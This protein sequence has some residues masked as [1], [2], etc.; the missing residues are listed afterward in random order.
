MQ[1]IFNSNQYTLNNTIKISTDKSITHR[2]IMLGSIAKGVTTVSDYLNSEDCLATLNIMRQLGVNIEQ[3]NNKLKINGVGLNGLKEPNDVLN[4]KNS[5]TTM[6][7]VSGILAAQNFMSVITGDKSLNSRP[8]KRIITP[9]TQMGARMYGKEGNN[10]A[11]LCILPVTGLSSIQYSPIVASAQVKSCVLLA[12][13]YA[14]GETIIHEKAVTRNHTENMLKAMAVD[15]TVNDKTIKLNGNQQLKAID[16]QVPGDFSTAAYFITL[17][18]CSKNSRL[19]I[20]DVGINET[21][22]G[23][24][25]VLIKMGANIKVSN[26]HLCNNEKIADLVVTSSQLQATTVNKNEIPTLID[27]VPLLAVIASH[28]DGITEIQGVEELKHKE[29]NRLLA[30]ITELTKIGVDIYC[31]N[32]NL[33]INGKNTKINTTKKHCFEHY[34]DHR[35]AM[36]LAIASL[37]HSLKSIIKDAEVVNISSPSFW[38]TLSSLVK[39]VMEVS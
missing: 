26:E 30:T 4:S 6:R 21:R 33:Y 28:V 14:N 5:G 1:V 2:A 15:L 32:D 20:K 16:I 10:K 9:L 25:N 36:S 8:M 7:L 17:A 35:I 38:H 18:L 34:N 13:L 22:T 39:Q 12:G 31:K 24:L 3:Y 23:L 27:E 37:T 19:T 11:P 29:S